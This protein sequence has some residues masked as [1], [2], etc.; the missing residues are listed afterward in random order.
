MDVFEIRVKRDRPLRRGEALTFFY[1]STEW[2]LAQPFECWCGAGGGVC[3]G[4]IAGAGEMEKGDLE[5]YWL[6]GYIEELLRE[7]KEQEGRKGGAV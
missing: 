1:P 3:C 2:T 6:N 7:K 4:R 5:R